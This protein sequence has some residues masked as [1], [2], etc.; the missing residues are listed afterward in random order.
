MA[1]KAFRWIMNLVA[2]SARVD[3][4]PC[5]VHKG[6][7]RWV[8]I[9]ADGKR[10]ERSPYAYASAAGARAAGEIRRREIG[11]KI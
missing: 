5:T 2:R 11:G 10:S 4:V 9:S 3:V 6:C 8:I 7:F 1:R